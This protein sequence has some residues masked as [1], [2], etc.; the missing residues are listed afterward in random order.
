MN[1]NSP[2]LFTWLAAL[3][4]GLLG[5]F[6]QLDVVSVPALERYISPFWMVSSGFGLLCVSNVVKWL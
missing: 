4:I 2:K 6:I 3:I 1:M 5:I